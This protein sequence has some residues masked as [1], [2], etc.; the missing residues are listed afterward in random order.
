MAAKQTTQILKRLRSLM[1][2]TTFVTEAIQA[3]I[4]P[5]GDAHQ[6]EYLA[7]SDQRRAFVSG[8]TGSAGTAVITET[9]AC[10]WT[11][12]RYFN[13]AEKQLDANWTLMKE[14]IPTT[15]TQGAWLAKTLPVGSKVGVDPRLFSKDQWTPL[16]KTLKSNGHI[17]VP[18]ERN[19]VDAIWDD[20][21]PPPSHV[22]QPLGIE[23][24]GKS[25][26]DK[27]KDVI[28][29]MDAKNCSLLLLTALDDIAWLLNLRGSDIQYNPVFFS[30]ALVKTNGEIHL[31]VD[32]SKVT[33]SVRQH[34]NLEADVEMAELVSSQTNNNVLAILHPYEDVDGFLAAEIPQQPKKIWISDK[35]AVAFSNLVAEDIL[36]SDVSPVVFM[37]AIKNP[38]EMA[39]MENAHIKD[40]AALCCFFAWLE[41][42]VESQRV[43]TEISAADKLAGFR[44]EQ[45]DFVGL[46]FDTISSSGSNA[47]IIHYKPSPETDRPINDREIYLCDSGGQ[48]KDGTT[49]VTR[50]V[51]FGCPTPFERQCF[52]R[53]LKGQMSL[54]TCL[55]PSKIKGNVLDVLARKALWD[56]GLD[57]LHGTSH[58]VGHYLCV[59]EGPMGISW[60]VYPDDPGLSENMVLSNEPGFYQDGEFGIRIENLVKI[61]PAK[62][63]NNFKDRKF[64]TFENLTFVPIQQKMIIAEMLTKEE[65]AYIDQYHTQCRDKVAPLLQKMNKKEGLNWLMRETEPVG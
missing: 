16:S 37:K 4:V 18:V 22:I 9:D 62:P 12:G 6:S 48:Y 7:D 49:D 24:T 17:L 53:V 40:A 38:V 10:L 59:H 35:S 31:F 20:K 30:W 27:V 2:D 65:V 1:K 45:A 32:P 44:A 34:L 19:I 28:Q 3:Y 8:F 50:T 58:G 60:R 57:Y 14:G 39:G 54:A 43:V 25:W 5:S 46:S 26:Q 61:V 13:Q 21:P 36:C 23:F 51:H 15:P 47:A 11:D 55:F 42:E 64:C 63:E 29:E 56:V 33:L 52:T 41:K